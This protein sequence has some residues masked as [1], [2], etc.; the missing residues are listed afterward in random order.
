MCINDDLESG[1]MD[2]LSRKSSGKSLNTSINRFSDSDNSK[3]LVSYTEISDDELD[4]I[5]FEGQQPMECPICLI[6]VRA[7]TK[8]EA[9]K[10]DILDI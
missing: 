1:I 10:S 7:H 8:L 5:E 4:Q 6:Q 2:S 3:K 9:V